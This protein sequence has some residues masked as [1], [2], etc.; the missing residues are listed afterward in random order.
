MRTVSVFVMVLA[1][2]ALCFGPRPALAQACQ[3]EEEMLKSSLK[4]V[5]DLVDT[6]KKETVSD[7]QNHYHQKSYLSKTSFLVKMAGGVVDCYQKAAQDATATKE[8]VDAYK[9]KRDSYTKLKARFEQTETAVKSTD[10]ANHAK[11][12]IAKS[13]YST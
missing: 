10:D 3:D 13:N 6:V 7:F 12:L 8:Q 2:L 9:A 4:D 1:G 11:D 5:S